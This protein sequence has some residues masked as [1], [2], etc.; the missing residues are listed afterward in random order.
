MSRVSTTGFVLHARPFRDNSR[1]LDLLTEAEGRTACLYRGRGA[2][3]RSFVRHELVWQGRGELK[4]LSLM[5]EQAAFDLPAPRLAC[6]FYLNELALKLLPRQ[7]PL[8]GLVDEYA[9]ALARL[10]DPQAALEPPLRRYELHLLRHLGEGLD[11]LDTGAL[12]AGG[13]YVYEPQR[14]LRPA[15][16]AEVSRGDFV[17]GGTL[18]ELLE[19]RLASRQARQEAKHM[20]RGL[21]DYHL[22][23][24]R[25]ISRALLRPHSPDHSRPRGVAPDNDA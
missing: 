7:I 9:E 11:S 1:V 6:G 25:I 19:G 4:T 3:C 20:L 12:D 21:L 24:R 5:E 15:S 2:A 10:A 8:E 14:G 13:A 23:G 16:A 18:R 22:Q 17:H